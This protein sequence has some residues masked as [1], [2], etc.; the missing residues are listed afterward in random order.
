MASSLSRRMIVVQL[1]RCLFRNLFF[2]KF[3]VVRELTL[4]EDETS[5]QI[6]AKDGILFSDGLED[7]GVDRPLVILSGDRKGLASQSPGLPLLGERRLLG[8]LSF[9]ILLWYFLPG[10]SQL[11]LD[12]RF[13]LLQ[14]LF[15]V[16]E[17][18]VV[19]FLIQLEI[20]EINF[21][22][23]R[24]DVTLVDTTKRNTID[25]EWTGNQK[26]SRIQLFQKDDSLG[27]ES[28][29]EEDQNGSRGDGF[30]QPCLSSGFSGVLATRSFLGI[31]SRALGEDGSSLSFLPIGLDLGSGALGCGL[32][33]SLGALAL[34]RLAFEGLA[35][36]LGQTASEESV[37]VESWH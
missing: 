1:I 34:R 19:I 12:G 7:N 8:L 10:S 24:N 29:S 18:A 6:S 15:R 17:I 26:K 4:P 5:S 30:P 23:G 9:G 36:V 20:S 31:R 2:L 22:P 35:G 11:N 13:A 3:H 14:L 21:G 25:F 27:L 37:F 32:L 16:L 33:D 28:T